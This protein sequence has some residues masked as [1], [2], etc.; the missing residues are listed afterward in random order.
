MGWF[1]KYKALKETRITRERR[2]YFKSSLR[3]IS[4]GPFYRVSVFR[5]GKTVKG[6]KQEGDASFVPFKNNNVVAVVWGTYWWGQEW[7]RLDQLGTCCHGTGERGTSLHHS[8]DGA[9]RERWRLGLREL[10][11]SCSVMSN[12]LRR[13]GLYSLWNSPG[14]NTGVGI[15]SLLQGIFP[16]Q[17]SNPGLLHCRWILYQL[18]NQGSPERVKGGTVRWGMW[19]VRKK[20]WGRHLHFWLMW[21]NDGD[22]L[23]V[24]NPGMGSDLEEGTMH[25]N[26]CLG[27]LILKWLWDSQR[28]SGK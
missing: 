18:R 2:K 15:L 8:G 24:E 9:G 22:S 11:D 17:G 1:S 4:A 13:H 10:N 7:M 26:L 23:V 14:R 27:M 28:V 20:Y 5:N 16:T 21:S 12:T 19:Q 3:K 6:F 25:L